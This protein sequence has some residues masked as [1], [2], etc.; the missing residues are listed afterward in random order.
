MFGVI[1]RR[2]ELGMENFLHSD[3]ATS[4]RRRT[5]LNGISG[6]ELAP[7]TLIHA[8]HPDPPINA[9]IKEDLVEY[10]ADAGFQTPMP[11]FSPNST[12]NQV[13]PNR[14]RAK[15]NENNHLLPSSV[16]C[17]TLLFTHQAQK[18]KQTISTRVPVHQ[19]KTVWNASKLCL[20]HHR[21]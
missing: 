11:V 15:Y 7:S 13:E 17:P 14:K 16:I 12:T 21:K 1:K 4:S 8:H 19:S 10:T 20:Q 9:K 3:T 5:W 2:R 6:K 18:T